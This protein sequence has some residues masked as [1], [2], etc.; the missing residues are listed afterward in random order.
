M[1]IRQPVLQ[2]VPSMDAGALQPRYDALRVNRGLDS[3]PFGQDVREANAP[4]HD[5]HDRDD[6]IAEVLKKG[7]PKRPPRPFGPVATRTRQIHFGLAIERDRLAGGREGV[8]KTI[9]R[10]EPL[11]GQRAVEDRRHPPQGFHRV[12]SPNESG[13]VAGSSI[14]QDPSYL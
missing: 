13:G 12:E 2:G 5:P 4:G 7:R 3:I 11:C 9:A 8:V 10:K 6:G 14:R 1:R